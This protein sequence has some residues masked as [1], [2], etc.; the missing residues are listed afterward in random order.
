MDSE[1]NIKHYVKEAR[2]T[3]LQKFY[4]HMNTAT[5]NLNSYNWF[6]E[7]MLQCNETEKKKSTRNQIDTDKQ[8]LIPVLVNRDGSSL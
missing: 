6:K 8:M 1:I 4:S 5:G 2:K 3:H 7:Y